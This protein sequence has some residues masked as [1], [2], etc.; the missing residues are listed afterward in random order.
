MSELQ[1]P[2]M[3]GCKGERRLRKL[4]ERVAHIDEQIAELQ[5]KKGIMQGEIAELGR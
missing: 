1:D 2:T 5:D 4:R 3:A